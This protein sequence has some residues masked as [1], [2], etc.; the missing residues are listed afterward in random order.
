MTVNAAV[1]TAITK[2]RLGSG[3]AATSSATALSALKILAR[4]ISGT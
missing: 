2:V 4:T 1:T 3:V